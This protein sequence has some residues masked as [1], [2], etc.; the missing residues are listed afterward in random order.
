MDNM[1]TSH[2]S[3]KAY[4]EYGEPVHFSFFSLSRRSVWTM[5]TSLF[6]LK[7]GRNTLDIIGIYPGIHEH[8]SRR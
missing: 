6:P 4:V 1:F 5:F 3:L 2:V 8:V 7:E